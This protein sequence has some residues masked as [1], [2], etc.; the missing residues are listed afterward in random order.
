MIEAL[1]FEIYF[2][3][4]IGHQRDVKRPKKGIC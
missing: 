2:L 3:N 1:G 4:A